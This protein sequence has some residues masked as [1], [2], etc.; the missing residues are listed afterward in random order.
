MSRSAANLA[1]YRFQ[2]TFRH[3][4]GGYLALAVLLGLIGGDDQFEIDL[5]V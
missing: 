2:V 4:L 3:R 5:F 1:W